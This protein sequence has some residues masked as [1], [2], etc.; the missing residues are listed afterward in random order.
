MQFYTISTSR[1]LDALYAS[2]LERFAQDSTD[3]AES[4]RDAVDLAA[5]FRARAACATRPH[6]I[7]EGARLLLVAALSYFAANECSPVRDVLDEAAVQADILDL[8]P[9]YEAETPGCI[10]GMA[11]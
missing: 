8:L 1:S 5:T 4:Y 10:H 7:S 9:E 3:A 2:A 6:Q 11:V